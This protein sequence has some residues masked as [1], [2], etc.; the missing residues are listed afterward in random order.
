[1]SLG[2]CSDA[3]P[4]SPH[5]PIEGAGGTDTAITCVLRVMVRVGHITQCPKHPAVLAFAWAC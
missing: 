2:E 1:M 4:P 3:Y 5:V